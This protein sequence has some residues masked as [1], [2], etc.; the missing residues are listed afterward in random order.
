MTTPAGP[1]TS[2]LREV[3]ATEICPLRL[4]TQSVVRLGWGVSVYSADTCP[5]TKNTLATALK[6][7]VMWGLQPCDHCVCVLQYLQR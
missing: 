7:L 6:S 1:T 3:R 4:L 5:W 2:V